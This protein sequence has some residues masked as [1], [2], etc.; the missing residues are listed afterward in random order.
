[1]LPSHAQN[2]EDLPDEC[3]PPLQQLVDD[4]ILAVV[5]GS[6]TTSS[7]LTSIFF[8]ILT[9]L[10]AYAMLQAEVDRFYP[11]S[12]DHSNTTHHREM[13]Y[14]NAVMWVSAC[15]PARFLR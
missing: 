15:S 5:A 2:D 14:L 1:M 4:G 8:C 13:T 11:A 10:E 9:H 3:P 6:D 7:C 12:E